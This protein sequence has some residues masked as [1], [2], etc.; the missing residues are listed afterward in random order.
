LV[1]V[2]GSGTKAEETVV[3]VWKICILCGI[4]AEAEE[5]VEHPAWL[6]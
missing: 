6:L 3:I 2:I 1:I 4:Y 5:T